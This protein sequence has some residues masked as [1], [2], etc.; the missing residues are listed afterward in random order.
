MPTYRITSDDPEKTRRIAMRL[1]GRDGTFTS[2]AVDGGDLLV[3]AERAPE[4][5]PALTVTEE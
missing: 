3:E 5:P 2:V 1:L 4:M